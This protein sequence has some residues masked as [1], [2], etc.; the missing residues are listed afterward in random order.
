[1]ANAIN[2]FE[3]PVTD[4][5]R[6]LK[7]YNQLLGAPLH[8]EQMG[9]FEMGFF[10]HQAGGVGGAICKGEGYTPS[11]DGSLLYLNGGE[12]LTAF[13]DR[14][15]PAGGKILQPKTLITDDIGYMA[16]FMDT[17]GNKLAF[18]SPK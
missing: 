17:E 14:V 5:D 13:L 11:A 3:I 8:V 15:E 4:F 18:H 16:I 10:A 7:F 9:G 2:W 12:D 1:M 6:A